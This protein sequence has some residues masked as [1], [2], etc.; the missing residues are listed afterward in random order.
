MIGN[1]FDQAVVVF[2]M[3]AWADLHRIRRVPAL[4]PIGGMPIDAQPQQARKG[5][6]SYTLRSETGA[7]V[8]VNLRQKA[9][10]I[11]TIGDP[12]HD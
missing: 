3:V 6:L 7:V 9:F 8:E 4:T 12:G 2:T 11:K 1:S 10:R 5:R